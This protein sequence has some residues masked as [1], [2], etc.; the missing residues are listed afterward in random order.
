[1]DTNSFDT[2]PLR[3]ETR[4]GGNGFTAKLESHS[5]VAHMGKT[6]D[7]SHERLGD[8]GLIRSRPFARLTTIAILAA[9]YFGAAKL[10]LK[11]AFVHASA[12]AVWPPTGIAMAA[13]LV[14]SYRVWPGIFLGA[15]LANITT[16]GSVATS[17]GIATGNTLE[18]LL[19][20]YLVN[21]FAHGR[22]TF[23]R[24]RDIFRFTVL[25]GIES[26]AVSATFGVTSLCLGGFANWSG[27][28]AIWLTWWL[29][30]AVG[31][32]TV[33][34]LL[35]LW[36]TKPRIRWNRRQLFEAGLLLF[37]LILVALA[38][39]GGWFPAENKNY[40]LEFIC[41]PLLFWTAFRFGQRETATA[42]L[43]LAGIAIWGTL[44]GFGPF[45]R[46][47]ANESLL[48]LQGFMGVT[49]VMTLSFAAV[50]AERKRID[51]A[52]RKAYKESDLRVQQRTAELSKVVET[53]EAEI[54]ER[55]KAEE[56]LSKLAEIVKSSDDAIISWTLDCAIIVSWN[57]GAERMFGYSADEAKGRLITLVI[58]S[59]RAEEL[60]EII[61][62]MKRGERL[63][64]YETRRLRR[65]GREIEVS[66]SLS[67]LKD[68]GGRITE[69]S[70][71]VRD[72]TERKRAEEVV[73][74]L[75]A[76][77]E[78][79]DDAII[80]KTMEGAIVSWNAGA[81][82]IFGYPPE[83]MLG[84]PCAI[85]FP[86][87]RSAEAPK[88]LARIKRGER[89]EHFE[90]KWIRRDRRQI[91]VSLTVS[92]IK[93]DTGKIIGISV[94][95]RDI[96]ERKQAEG[97][98]RQLNEEL[99]QRVHQRTAQLEAANKELEAFSYS[100]S[101]DLAAPLRSINGF[102]QALLED[103]AEKLDAQGKDYLQRVRAASQRMARLIS[104]MLNLARVTRAEM[105]RESVDLNALARLV[106]AELQQTDLSRRVE[107][108]I[109]DGVVANGDARL[110]QVVLE[111]LLGNAWKFTSKH[112]T[113][114]IEFGVLES[115]TNGDGKPIYFVRDDG[116]GFD[117]T[118]AHKMFDAFQRLHD[119]GEFEGNGIGLASVQ[120]V[121]NRHGGRVWAEGEVE[122]GAT[123]YFT[124]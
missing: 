50:V 108:V 88:I 99:E 54:I 85:L 98:I 81:A 110:L 90:T 103:Y 107:F 46:E 21:R 104:D 15:F 31:A 74:Q 124:L 100:V 84:R 7:A 70:A 111:N 97:E 102:S 121:I 105:H 116:A 58:P 2:I 122:R 63:E 18:G 26:T 78:S 41:G 29:G 113:A 19:G 101:H 35:V 39:F 38:V 45:A 11:L 86:S 109:A 47:N 80:S 68:A 61:E 106:A 112:P 25:A 53:L 76:I 16:A 87:D 14:L 118:F 22:N 66:L 62:S 52:L 30:D 3:L 119:T 24:P 59:D 60:P 9:V 8:D 94:I 72:I 120:R 37:A 33:A 123:F 92:P 69:V 1:M 117:K 114:R 79:S 83:A 43:V 4:V 27:Y 13:F 96:T 89:V 91:D 28:G 93:E 32:L 75:A 10:G 23:D 73:R 55:K 95:A 34:P 82:R 48:L 77:V 71:I 12:T 56:A 65:D 57:P 115:D 51:E 36:I 67:P 6:L 44:N 40:P 42:T 49:A 64:H 17:I 5:A 20:A